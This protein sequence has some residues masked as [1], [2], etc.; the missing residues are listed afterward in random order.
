SE[1]SNF[2]SII[3]EHAARAVNGSD[4]GVLQL[5]RISPYNEQAVVPSRFRIGDLE[6]MVKAAIDDA[7]G[8]NVYIEARTVRPELRGKKRGALADTVLVFGRVIDS[9]ADKGK[10]GRIIAEPTLKVAT[11]AGNYHLWY[12]FDQAIP[13]WQAKPIGDALRKRAGAD[14]D[15]G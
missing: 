11:S 13:A 1:L 15:S 12:L 3:H 6:L 4:A 2:D 8:H 14:A 5:C 10:A 7:A 9:V